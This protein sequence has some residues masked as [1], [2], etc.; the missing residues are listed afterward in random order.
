MKPKTVIVNA[1]ATIKEG[2]LKGQTGLVVGYESD[3]NEVWI[4][5]DDNTTTLV[6]VEMIEQENNISDID[7]ET[8][9]SDS[10]SIEDLKHIA[11]EYGKLVNEHAHLLHFKETAEKLLTKEHLEEIEEEMENIPEVNYSF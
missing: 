7:K 10:L 6:K 4:S 3:I 2:V 11:E 1:N 8:K 5:L 9:F